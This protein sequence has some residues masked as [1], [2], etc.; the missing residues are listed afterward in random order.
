M[1]TS[2][3]TRTQR[4]EG[5]ELR[6]A[7][8]TAERLRRQKASRRKLARR[9]PGGRIL[10]RVHS[11]SS[12]ARRGTVAALVVLAAATVWWAAEVSA[13]HTAEDTLLVRTIPAREVQVV[14]RSSDWFAPKSGPSVDVDIDGKAVRLGHGVFDA[15]DLTVGSKIAVVVD[16]SDRS[17]I[18]AVG[19][20]G[21]WDDTTSD[22]VVTAA[23]TGVG[24][25]FFLCMIAAVLLGPELEAWEAKRRTTQREK[26]AVAALKGASRP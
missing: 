5:A 22:W 15:R 6:E 1:A 26:A 2:K 3:K 20:P 8:R 9:T 4:R 16:P 17:H 11:W 13:T 25:A 19:V 21:D 24:T 7:R 14:K 18:V 12:G 10:L 23:A